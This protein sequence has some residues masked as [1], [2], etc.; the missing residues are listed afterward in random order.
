MARSAITLATATRNGTGTDVTADAVDISNEHSL[1]VSGYKGDRIVLRFYGGS[2]AGF[3][4]T[5]KAG[6]FS[7]S[8]IGD[9]VCAKVTG[10]ATHVVSFET[11][12]FKDSDELILIDAASTGTATAATIE[13]ILLP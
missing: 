4:P 10:G 13:A 8:S 9:L 11:A 7:G 1:D 3:T 2:A 12:R 5:I 6:D